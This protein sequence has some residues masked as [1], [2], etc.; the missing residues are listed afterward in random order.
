METAGERTCDIGSVAAIPRQRATRL[1]LEPAAQ[2]DAQPS[3]MSG[4]ASVSH[5]KLFGV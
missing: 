2:G 1:R 3:V 4:L 5:A